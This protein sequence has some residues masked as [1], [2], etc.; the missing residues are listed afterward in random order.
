MKELEPK[1]DRKKIQTNKGTP[2]RQRW[3]RAVL[4]QAVRD[5]VLNNRKFVDFYNPEWANIR[6]VDHALWFIN[7]E[8]VDMG[9]YS[10]YCSIVQ[11]D[12][13]LI[14]NAIRD[15][16]WDMLTRISKIPFH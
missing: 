8:A 5:I 4:V 12:P 11:I 9:S 3:A 16:D 2:S 1:T 15:G 7:D 6:C 14:R 10:W 13:D